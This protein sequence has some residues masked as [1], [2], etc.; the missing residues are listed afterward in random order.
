[1]NNIPNKTLFKIAKRTENRKLG[2]VVVVSSSPKTCP[3]NC[4]FKNNG[5]YA[6]Y[7]PI[8]LHWR[9]I[10]Q[11]GINC[12]DLCNEIN[13]LPVYLP[14]RFWDAGDF[15]GNGITLNRKE[16]IQIGNVIKKRTETKNY[17]YTHYDMNIQENRTVVRMLLRRNLIANISTTMYQADNLLNKYNFPVV[18]VAPEPCSQTPSGHKIVM[19]PNQMAK[20][21]KQDGVLTCDKCLLCAQ[22][23]RDYAIG[24][25]P[26]GTNKNKVLAI[27]RTSLER[28]IYDK[29]RKKNKK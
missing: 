2:N 20:L 10:D 27:A 14:I 22:W 25:L 21:N 24:F 18:I 29:N 4:E 17:A 23:P 6:E 19:C 13:N 1:M 3:L 11:K 16:C 8:S 7:G 9:R 5:C 15:P 28:T 12:S 26:H